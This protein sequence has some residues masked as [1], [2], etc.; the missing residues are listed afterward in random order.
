MVPPDEIQ[1]PKWPPPFV[2]SGM[3][4][5][6]QTNVGRYDGIAIAPA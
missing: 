2:G 6:E 4:Q 3:L 1:G 5:S